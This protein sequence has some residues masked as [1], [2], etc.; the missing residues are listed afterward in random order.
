[1]TSRVAAVVLV[2]VG[3]AAL[4]VGLG[5]RV[6]LGDDE[7]H[8][9]GRTPTFAL[10]AARGAD[11][12]IVD[13]DG[14]GQVT[15]TIERAGQQLIDFDD[16]HGAP[17]HVYAVAYDGAWFAHVDPQLRP[18]G[19]TAPFGLPP[20]DARLVVQTAPGGG[21]DLHE[22]GIDVTIPAGAAP[23][24]PGSTTNVADGDVWTDGELTVAERFPDFVLSEPWNGEDYHD[25]PALL[26]LFRLDDGAFIHAHAELVDDD[27]FRFAAELP[28]RGEYL[29]A[30]QFE[31]D[32][33]IVT[34]AYVIEI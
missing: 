9:D 11:E 27:R 32:G 26:S 33:E 23:S 21:P 15:V 8:H 17:V 34:A 20:G 10:S 28:G 29:A 1:M 13:V 22:L 24:P 31:Q 12:L 16:V 25:G 19:S 30:V 3:A 14:S 18:D 6:F 2:V 7:G 4:V 5:L